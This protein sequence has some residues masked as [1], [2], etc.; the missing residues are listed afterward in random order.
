M[1]QTF[2]PYQVLQ[3]PRNFTLD[4]L[5]SQYK[6][7]ALQLHPDKNNPMTTTMFQ[8][9]TSCYKKLLKEHELRQNDKGYNQLKQ[10]SHTYMNEQVSTQRQNTELPPATPS[11]K[12]KFD[13]ERF[14]MV[15]NNNRIKD[16]YEEGY[17]SWLRSEQAPSKNDNKHVVLYKKPEP[18]PAASVKLHASE[19]GIERISDFSGQN[20]SIRNL[21]YMDLRA[22]HTTDRLIDEA[23]VLQRS[24]YRTVNEL[25]TARASANLQPTE[26][27]VE[28]MHR[29]QR[30]NQKLEQRRIERLQNYDRQAEEVFN[31]VH[32]LMLGR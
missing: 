18:L 32:K 25:E 23:N 8:I 5:K 31:R 12:T 13:P 26:K 11:S 21:N 20:T 7:Q 3:L 6:K 30:K 27:D 4:M 17:E 28:R 22:A 2:D 24:S 16:A 15:F 14:N 1:Q 29:E 9:L 19:L 10:M